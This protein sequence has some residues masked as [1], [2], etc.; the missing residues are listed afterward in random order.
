MSAPAAKVSKKDPASGQAEALEICKEQGEAI[1]QI[2]EVQNE[3]DRLNEQ[4]S[5]EILRVERSYSALRRPF[6]QKRAEW[7]A[8]IPG[9]WVTA[10]FSH[11]QLSL[12]FGEEDE[13]ALRHLARIQV[14]EFQDA[15]SGYRIEFYFDENPFFDNKVISKEYYLDESGDLTSKSCEID[16]KPGKDLTK[17]PS[18]PQTNKGARKRFREESDSFFTWFSDHTDAAAD[19]LGEVIKDDIW[20][21]PLQYYLL[22]DLDSQEGDGDVEELDTLE[23]GDGEEEESEEEEDNGEGDHEGE[24]GGEKTGEN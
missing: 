18:Q 5:A 8:K 15:K 9:F 11:P 22:S 10:L 3:I 6:L 2:D 19:E 20:L 21:N 1:E 24:E 4:A 14:T 7:I 16:W 13:E 12:L 17:P 23:E